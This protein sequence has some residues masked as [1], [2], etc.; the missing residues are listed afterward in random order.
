MNKHVIVR[1][2]DR[3]DSS[4]IDRLAVAGTATVHEAIG[5]VGYVGPHLKPIQLDTKIAGSAVTV[6]SHPGDNI[7]IHAAVEM[8]QPGDVL[9]VANTAPST[10]GM[11]GDLLA[12]SLMARGVRGL[13]IDAGV[14][15]T[16]DLRSMGFPVWAQ[17]VSCQ[18]TVKNSPGSVNVPVILGGVTV[19]PGDVVC[20]DDDGVVIVERADAAWAL[21]RSDARLAREEKMRVTLESG[22]LG[23]DVYG[24]RQKLND[25]GVEYID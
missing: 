12:T 11:F 25:M 3:A 4:V 13:I 2:I 20:A 24:L 10:H 18:G 21:E 19:Q 1:N 8:C 9:V 17:H 22:E 16:A 14:R 6:L 15:D 7:M 5:R 23:V